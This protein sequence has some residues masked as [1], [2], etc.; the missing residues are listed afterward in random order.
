MPKVKITERSI[1]P[2]RA[3]SDVIR[4]DCA[5]VIAFIGTVRGKSDDEEFR[6]TEVG[7]CS[8]NDTD[9]LTRIVNDAFE[10]FRLGEIILVYRIGILQVGDI[11]LTVAVSAARRKEAFEACT[12]VMDRIRDTTTIWDGETFEKTVESRI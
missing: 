7:K 10:K 1:D 2:S 9:Q 12:E 11:V 8:D 3:I 4:N 6:E 5:A